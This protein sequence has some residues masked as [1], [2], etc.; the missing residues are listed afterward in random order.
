MNGANALNERLRGLYRSVWP[1]LDALIP[2]GEDYSW[3]LLIKATEAYVESPTRLMIVGQETYGWY[4]HFA[5]GRSERITGIQ[6]HYAEF[7]FAARYK[8]TPFW[9]AV[10]R[11]RSTVAS[12]SDR[13]AL[14]WSNLLPVDKAQK[15]P[16]ALEGHLAKLG[17][18]RREIEVLKPDV[19]VFFTGPDYD[20]LVARQFP[21]VLH[22]TVGGY[23][24]RTLSRLAHAGLPTKSF[25][26][27]HPAYLSR[28][29]QFD[30]V[31]GRLTELCLE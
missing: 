17:I 6:D 20:G 9:R 4:G 1:A 27:Y 18:L 2:G 16:W 24:L 3:P 13:R 15:R 21:G 19:V 11:L 31:L 25:R 28:S 10:H 12:S 5:P 14:A 26:T 23:D 22:Q 29:R 30:R 8:S 7:D